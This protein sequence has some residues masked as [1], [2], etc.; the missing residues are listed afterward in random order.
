MRNTF[1]GYLE[2]SNDNETAGRNV[3]I[4]P[5]HNALRFD[6]VPPSPPLSLSLYIHLLPDLPSLLSRS[7]VYVSA[8]GWHFTSEIKLDIGTVCRRVIANSELANEISRLALRQ[9]RQIGV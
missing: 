1:E 7:P 6:K 5:A 2:H 9:T 8:D 4:L 3:E